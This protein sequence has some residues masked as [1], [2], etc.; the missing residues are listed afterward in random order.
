MRSPGCW[1]ATTMPCFATIISATIL[2][3]YDY[4]NCGREDFLGG[5]LN[6]TGQYISQYRCAVHGDL[7]R[8]GKS[9]KMIGLGSRKSGQFNKLPSTSE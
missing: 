6:K 8:G 4:K 2:I 5:Y 1:T 3:I 9:P 7:F